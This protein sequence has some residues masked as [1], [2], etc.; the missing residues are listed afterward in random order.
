[1]PADRALARL[2]WFRRL[3]DGV[4]DLVYPTEMLRLLRLFDMP[5]RVVVTMDGVAATGTKLHREPP[6]PRQ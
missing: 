4:F 3:N 2:R 1:M 6:P 5:F